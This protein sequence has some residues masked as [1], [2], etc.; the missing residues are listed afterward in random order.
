MTILEQIR[1]E[2]PWLDI[3]T[4]YDLRRGKPS[5]LQLDVTQSIFESIQIPFEMDAIDLRNYGEP[6]GIPS[7]R[8]LGAEIL[9]TKES[10]TIALDNASLTLIHQILTCSY[11]FGFQ[12]SKIHS[13]S[14]I[15]CPSPGYDRH[16]KLIENFGIE[17]ITVPFQDDGPDLN[18]I[19]T[20]L[21][22]EKNIDGIVCVP[23][24]SNPTGH[25]YSDSNVRSMFKMFAPLHKNFMILWDN[26]YAC[27]D[28][29][30]T[31]SQTNASVIAKEFN[32]EDNIF[33]FGST[34]KMT[35][36][37]SGI[38]F[39]SSSKENIDKFIDYRNSVTVGPNKMNQGLHVEYFKIMPIK[40]QMQKMKEILLP[41][42]DIT[43]HYLGML[44]DERLGSFSNPTGGYFFSFDSKKSN[45][46]E[47]ID[48]C[49]KLNLKLLPP[50]SSFPYNDDPNKNNIR[51]A[52]TFP[53]NDEL[54]KSMK[55]LT[56]V[57]K[58]LN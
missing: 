17:M 46:E 10:E 52:P 41:K 55:I 57:V 35:L 33:H 12:S 37:G 29:K 34:S 48:T 23:R 22:K 30:E 26:A 40:K 58:H 31:I 53:T 43:D 51:I 5:K 47:I 8:A 50:G 7:A 28:L 9:G 13:E 11:F 3:N 4:S 15:L 27:H 24:H 36:A 42:F 19:E 38:S 39:L 6:E 2:H 20:I 18:A 32:L 45:C 21:K 16:F 54:E 14:K 1:K 44:K 56:S 25:T 49:Q